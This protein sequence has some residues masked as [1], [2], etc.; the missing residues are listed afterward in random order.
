MSLSG[1]RLKRIVSGIQPSGTLHLGNY[2]GAVK[3]WKNLINDYNKETE[4]K[5]DSKKNVLYFIA[6]YHSLTSRLAAEKQD[7]LKTSESLETL[8]L[9]TV[10][11]LIASGVDYNKASLFLQS[12]IPY[13]TELQWILSC[14]TPNSWL[15]TMI[16]YKEK[17]IDSNGIFSYPVLM[18]ADVLLYKASHVPV[19]SDQTQHIELIAKI[20]DRINKVSKKK[21]FIRPEAISSDYPRVMSL[22]DGTKKM[23]KSDSSTLGC[24]Y[25]TDSKETIIKKITKSKTDSI[26]T[27]K[28]DKENRPEISN[29]ISIYHSITGESIKNIENKFEKA[30]TVEFKNKLVEVICEEILPISEKANKLIKHEKDLL[31]DVLREGEKTCSIIAKDTMEELKERLGIFSFPKLH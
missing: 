21:I 12:S 5:L 16:Q 30:S 7:E 8:T 18:A 27:I 31:L 11:C 2:L 15:N 13:H 23:S 25:L 20:T 29:L 26:G 22:I 3:E 1:S 4:Y 24:I 19:G 14:V 28:F 6:D 17:K 10:A 9:N